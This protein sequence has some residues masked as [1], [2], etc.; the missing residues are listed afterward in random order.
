MNNMF[1]LGHRYP[2]TAEYHELQVPFSMT[3]DDV[4]ADSRSQERGQTPYQDKREKLL[5]QQSPP[6]LGKPI[7]KKK[8]HIRDILITLLSLLY[9]VIAIVTVA[10]ESISWRLGVGTR[11]LIVLGFLLS[12]MN[13]CLGSLAPT[14]FLL[15]EAKFGDGILRNR[16]LSSRLSLTWRMTCTQF[17]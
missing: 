10:N 7:R 8:I 2:A 3:G 13:L 12:I 17:L 6:P 14:T 5:Q 4:E 15:L 9:L 16:P 11:Q 1:S